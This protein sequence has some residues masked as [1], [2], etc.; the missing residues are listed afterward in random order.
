MTTPCPRGSAPTGQGPGPGRRAGGMRIAGFAVRL[1]AGAYVL[2]TL[3]VVVSTLTL[4]AQLPDG[5][6][7]PTLPRRP[8]QSSS[9]AA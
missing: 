9:W 3:A 7:A 5:R 6:L 1:T 2:A 4:R 8:A